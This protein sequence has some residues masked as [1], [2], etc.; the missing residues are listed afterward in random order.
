MNKTLKSLW[1]FLIFTFAAAAM[2]TAALAPV[3]PRSIDQGI[4]G[5]SAWK[6]D[7]SA[8]T[9][10]VSAVSLPLPSGASTAAKQAALGTAG[11]ASTDVISVQGIASM[12]PV[13]ATLSGT[14]NLNNIAGT[15]SL[16]TGAAT[17]ALQSALQTPISPTTASATVGALLGGQYNSTQATF[18]NG[19]QGA[20]QIS[21]RGEL[22]QNLM[23]AAGN[24]RGVN[25]TSTNDA[26]VQANHGGATGSAVPSRAAYQGANVGGNLTG[27]IKCGSSAVYDASTSGRTQIVAASGS[28]V[29]YICGYSITVGGTATNVKLDYGTGTNCGTS[30]A[31]ITPAFQ[32]AA[33]G[34]IVDGSPEY[35]GLK[36][37]A[38]QALCIN[39]SAANAVQA[40]VYYT[41]F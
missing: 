33:N 6:V 13:L 26:Q 25:V 23:D 21:S 36:T 3:S 18:T 20:L 31:S 39:A 24:A 38:S 32:I 37:I 10:P 1:F 11:S 35:R 4:G 8:V 16:P 34:G 17:S 19:Q 28:T 9:Q 15:I 12:T 7:G 29:I 30:P 22:K 5:T 40:I 41:Q 2:T 27:A 14:N